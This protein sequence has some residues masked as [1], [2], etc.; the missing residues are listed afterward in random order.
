MGNQVLEQRSDFD[1][2]EIQRRVFLAIED[3]STH[4]YYL[5]EMGAGERAI[6]HRFAVWLEK[7][8]PGWHVDCEYDILLYEINDVITKKVT[9]ISIKRKDGKLKHLTE[10]EEANV[11]PDVIVHRRGSRDNLLVIEIK[12]SLDEDF[13]AYDLEKLRAYC[14]DP[15]LGYKFGL[16]I[17]FKD[18]REDGLIV[19]SELTNWID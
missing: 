11:I 12:K 3:L 18:P 2:T 17:R 15:A 5:F 4:D 14:S 13:I 7:V 19:D 16:F 8:F 1:I 6:A 10:P 9:Q